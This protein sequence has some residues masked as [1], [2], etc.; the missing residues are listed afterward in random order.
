M[1]TRSIGV[2][3]WLALACPALASAQTRV[4]VGDFKGPSG[5]QVRAA[6]EDV[7][8]DH[9]IELVSPKKA[10]ATARSSG[11]ELDTESGRVR[12]ARKLR[13]RAFVEGRTQVSKRRIRVTVLVFN[14][15][16]GMQASEYTTA[17]PK[18]GLVRDVR[19][20]LWSAIDTALA[21]EAPPAEISE[22]PVAE[23]PA[24]TAAPAKSVPV[25]A[26]DEE[27]PGI[28]S[29]DAEDQEPGLA[30]HADQEESN[31]E[32]PS[33]LDLGIGARLGTRAFGYNDSLPGLRGYSLGFS[34]SVALRARW[35]PAAHF[36]AGALAHIGLDLRGEFLVGVS[37]K[38]SAG[39]KFSTS[40]HAFGIGLRARLPLDKLEL[41]GVAGF[42]QHAFGFANANGKIDPDIPDVTYNFVRIGLDARWQFVGPLTLQ[43]AAAYLLGLSQGEIA[44]RAWFPHSTGNGFEAEIGLAYP[45]S[46]MIALELS[47][48]LQ[49]YFL[50]LNPEP[51][52][53]G[54]VGTGRVAGGALDQYLSTR[55]G[56]VIRP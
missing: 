27:T 16:D 56:V 48:A 40:S 30:E 29:R 11:A 52:D 50:S 25:P 28:A 45:V 22:K 37:S 8:E 1:R 17:A 33:P 13:L 12:V 7:L 3:C 23:R 36:V 31:G 6:V 49:R 46:R 4:V 39:Q 9:G 14:G 55:L 20:G 15:A 47:F 2:L 38:N 10:A 51:K 18:S 26:T 21:G 5:K 54:V 44:E 24:R 32:R 34:P 41:G 19:A 53:P 43:L 42:G 35:Y